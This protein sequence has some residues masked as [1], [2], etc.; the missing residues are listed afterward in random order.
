MRTTETTLNTVAAATG[1]AMVMAWFL[2]LGP[3]GLLLMLGVAYAMV[4]QNL[5]LGV[6]CGLPLASPFVLT[7]IW[8]PVGWGAA[9]REKWAGETTVVPVSETAK[10]T[11][12]VD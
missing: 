5:A 7:A 9:L 11:I 1:S 8:I 6:V 2:I 12:G 10:E 4:V 3:L